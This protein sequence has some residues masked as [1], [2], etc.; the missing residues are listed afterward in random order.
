MTGAQSPVGLLF[1]HGVPYCL[2]LLVFMPGIF[3]LQVSFYKGENIVFDV[4]PERMEFTVEHQ[5]VKITV[6]TLC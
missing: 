1:Q 2:L 4:K 5:S 3:S 6:R